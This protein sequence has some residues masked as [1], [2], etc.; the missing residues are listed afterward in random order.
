MRFL[1][2]LSTLLVSTRL[3]TL[4]ASAL[5]GTL[6]FSDGEK[7]TFEY[8]APTANEK[9]WIGIYHT[10]GGP[11]DQKQHDPSLKWAYAPKAKGSVQIDVPVR[12]SGEYKAYFL[13]DDGYKWVAD[14]I[15]F[16]PRSRNENPT[17]E[18]RV[19]T[20]NL[21][22]GGSNFNNYH[23]K[24]I[25]FLTKSGVDIIGLQEASGAHAKRLANALGWN[26]HQANTADTAAI[27]SRHPIVKRHNK[28]IERSAGVA[29]NIDSN[30][31]KGI[32]FWSI[33]TTAYPYGPYEFC[34]EGKNNEG[35]MGAEK[36]SGR[37]QEI[38]DVID[39]TESQ[40]NSSSPFILVGDFNAP[41]QLDWTDALKGKHCGASFKWPTSKIPIDAGLKDSFRL[42]HSDPAK[43]PG[44]TWSPIDKHNDDENK[45][46]P[47][48]R[49]DFI[50]H[51]DKLKVVDSKVT[52]AGTPKPMPNHLGNEWT[53]DH[54][55]VLTTYKLG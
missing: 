31:S 12:A 8:S 24:Q 48:D 9:N 41:S 2:T 11:D 28:L 19:M 53:S 54:A 36:E 33:H 43:V 27:V 21:W 7:F 26:Y 30:P 16:T 17:N 49:I 47:Q 22:S 44:D 39:G 6:K 23:E 55:A 13:A 40:R 32:N 18:L 50:Y 5:A 42:V 34:F 20:Y 15:T 52:V 25:N 37:I 10:S 1:T 29:I 38:T 46:E 3:H 14:P 51:T 35:V 45:D 4:A